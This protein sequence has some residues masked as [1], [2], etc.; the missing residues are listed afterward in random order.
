MANGASLV[1]YERSP[2]IICDVD[3]VILL[4]LDSST[5][6]T[7][8]LDSDRKQHGARDPRD[9]VTMWIAFEC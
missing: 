4:P 5:N 7:Y 6:S 3:S 9:V 2:V 8:S 1:P